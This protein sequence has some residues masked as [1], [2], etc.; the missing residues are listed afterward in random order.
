MKNLSPDERKLLLI[1]GLD[2]LAA[3]LAG[4]FVTVFFFAHGDL[5]VTIL[6]N[7][8]G[9]ASMTFFYG[10]SGLLLR[11]FSSGTLMK[12]SLVAGSIFYLLL[13]FLK[14]QSVAYVVPLGILSGF[15]GGIYWATYNLNQYILTH[16]GRLISFF[17]WTGAVFNFANAAGPAIG[18]LIITVVGKTSLGITNGYLALFFLVALIN[19][20]TIFIIGKLPTHDDLS[21]SYRHIWQHQRS[22]KWNLMLGQNALLGLYDVAIGTVTGILF[23]V[24]VKQEVLLGFILTMASIFAAIASLYAIPL[25]KKFPSSF[26]IGSIGSAVSIIIFAIFQSPIGV[27]AHIIISG[28]TVPIVNNKFSTVYYQVLDQTPGNWQEKYHLML[29]RDVVLG[30][31]RTLSYIVFFVLLGFGSEIEIAKYWL[32]ILPI[33]PIG[34]GFCIQ[35]TIT[36]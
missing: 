19:M 2:I 21:F 10:F 3:S 7:I 14:D 4:I 6:Y 29:E 34:I 5:K 11:Y 26:W 1:Q 31:F 30:M 13:F 15:S 18:G 20:V 35:K 17:G 9:F 33:I 28:F 12:T 36:A 16:K 8:A 32:F 22:N 27:W 23:F 24:I 25:L